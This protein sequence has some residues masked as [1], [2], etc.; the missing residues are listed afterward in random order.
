LAAV[1]LPVL[2]GGS[3]QACGINNAGQVAMTSTMPSG[4]PHAVRVEAD[5]R[6]YED[7]GSFDGPTGMSGACAIDEIGHI[8][9]YASA[10]SFAIF[11]AFRFDPGYLISVD[12]GLPSTFANVESVA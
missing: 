8:G 7:V 3:D 11:H 5:D 10:N 6:S 2:G 12:D 1:Q 4:L 9:G